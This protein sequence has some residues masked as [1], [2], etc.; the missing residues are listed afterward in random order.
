MLF[1]SSRFPSTSLATIS[2][3]ALASQR[4][5]LTPCEVAARIAGF[6]KLLGPA[7]IQVLE[8]PFSAAQLSDAVLAA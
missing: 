3:S 4:K 5:S 2:F 8:D 6:Q 1:L 7:V